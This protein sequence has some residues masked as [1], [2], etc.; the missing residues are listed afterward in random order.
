MAS[1][2]MSEDEFTRFLNEIL[3]LAGSH[4]AGGA[5]TKI[6]GID[7]GINSLS[8]S[9]DGTRIAFVGTLRGK[10]IRSYSQADL[11]V[12]D[13]VPNSSPKNLTTSYDFDISGGIGG[14]QAAPRG[15]NRK[16]ILWTKDQQALVV[17]SAER[18]SSNLKRVTIASQKVEPFTDGTQDVVAVTATPDLSKSAAS[19]STFVVSH[20]RSAPFSTSSFA[21][22]SRRSPY[23][24]GSNPASVK[25]RRSLL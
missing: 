5:I 15:Q 22:A 13:A 19:L 3:E 17:V 8:V 18:G 10:P 21:Q 4:A 7:G 12:T 1:G 14:D 9:P 24:A 25:T 6:A 11:W 23:S 20:P 16:P 2:E